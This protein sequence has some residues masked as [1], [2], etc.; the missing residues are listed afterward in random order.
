MATGPSFRAL[1]DGV[2]D[3]SG[4]LFSLGHGGLL[5]LATNTQIRLVG[6][7]DDVLDRFMEDVGGIVKFVIPPNV[8]KGQDSAITTFGGVVLLFT[9]DDLSNDLAYK[10]TKA[11]WDNLAE[12][13]KDRSFKDLVKKQAFLK[14]LK[15]PYHPG[16]LKYMREAGFI[17]K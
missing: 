9:R 10:V 7:P 13:N 6:I 11:F 3:A 14:N 12:L 5:E 8:Y 4:N 15:V 16:A 1:Q 2:I 17:A